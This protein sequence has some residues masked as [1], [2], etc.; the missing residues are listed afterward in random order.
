MDHKEAQKI[1]EETF[2]QKYFSWDNLEK[3]FEVYL[4]CDDFQWV[5]LT[6]P[7]IKRLLLIR[8]MTSKNERK[9]EG[10]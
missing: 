9:K 1:F 10:R 6:S 4:A 7:F 5:S 2:F 8:E 3:I